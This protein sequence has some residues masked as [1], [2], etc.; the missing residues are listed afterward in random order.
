[1][2]RAETVGPVPLGFARIDSS[3]RSFHL[4]MALSVASLGPNPTMGQ[5]PPG[6][7]AASAGRAVVATPVRVAT[8]RAAT[9]SRVVAS[10]CF[11]RSSLSAVRGPSTATRRRRS[12]GRYSTSCAGKRVTGSEG[13]AA[14]P[15]SDPERGGRHEV[16]VRTPAQESTTELPD[17]QIPS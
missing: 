12:A 8:T 7:F 13:P 2:D 3:S 6:P 9:S 15:S 11:T 4:R 14:L 1:M 16:Q 17:R 10:L 5:L